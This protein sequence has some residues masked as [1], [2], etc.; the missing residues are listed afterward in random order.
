[1]TRAMILI[2]FFVSTAI[3]ATSCGDGEG[4]V[5]CC[6][7]E[8]RSTGCGGTGWK[9][10]QSESHEF[11]LDDYKEGWDAQR[12][13]DKFSGSDTECGGSCCINVEYRNTQLSSGGC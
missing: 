12:V 6:R 8:K 10:W 3:V 1:M 13:C 2:L 5:F 7:Y 11:N 4:E 9:A